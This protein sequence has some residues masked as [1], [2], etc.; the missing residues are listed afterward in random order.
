VGP[1]ISKLEKLDV[2]QPKL[3]GKNLSCQVL[4]VDVF[5]NVIT[6]VGQ[7]M[8]QKI[9]L[10]FGE[11]VE[12]RS[13][14]RKLQAQYARSYYEVDKGAIAVLIGSQGFLEIAIREE[15]ARHKLDVKPLDKLEL[16]F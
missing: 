9:H 2:S 11:G 7:D 6:N 8:F 16:R 10:K 12:I 4:H 3:S 5:G 1:R 15:D 14:T 13:G